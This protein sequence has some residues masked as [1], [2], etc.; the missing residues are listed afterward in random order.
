YTGA[1]AKTPAII[2][3]N[4]QAVYTGE[5]VNEK[6]VGTGGYQNAA[7]LPSAFLIE[8]IESVDASIGDIVDA[9][10]NTGLYDNN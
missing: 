2:G 3:T 10:R 7:A 1:A 8:E 6:G 4:F 9:L 5:S